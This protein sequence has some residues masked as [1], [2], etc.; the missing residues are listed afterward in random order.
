MSHWRVV[1]VLALIAFPIVFLAGVGGYFMW[2]E[3]IGFYL[4]WPMAASMAAGYL[5]G[6][7]WQRKRQLLPPID[8]TPSMHWT[9]RDR[10]AWQLVEARAKAAER[11]EPARLVEFDFYVKTAEEMAL[12][13]ARFYH[14]RAAD[15]FG[16]RTIPEI[17]AV[18]ELAAHDLA[19]MVDRYLPGGHLLTVDQWRKA[20]QAAEWYQS[21]SNAYWLV[22]ALFSPLNTGLRYAAS[23]VGL[24]KPWQMLQQNLL[25][26]FYTGFVHRTGTYL[27][28]LNSGRLRVGVQRY[29]QLV[30][31]QLPTDQRE[32]E[33]GLPEK[34][35]AD[36]VRRVVITLMGQVK[37][38]KSSLINALLGEQRAQTDVL[39]ATSEVQRYELQ[40]KG[41]PTRLVLL[42]T[43]GYGHEGPRA[44]Q[45]KATEDAAQQSDLLLLVLHARNP[46]RQA[47]LEM[48]RRLRAWFASRPDLRMPPVVAVLTHIDLL[49]PAME[50]APPYNWQ[51]PGRPKE[52]QIEQAV[53]AVREQLGEY[54]AGVVPV[55]T[56][57]GKV[58]GINEWLLP[59]V[60]ALLDEVHAVALLRCLRAEI[61]A[62]KVRKVFHQLLAAGRELVR[63]VWQNLPSQADLLREQRRG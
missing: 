33:A 18:I 35:A 9:D 27:I 20:R 38:G 32:A 40:P 41:I 21:A 12:E 50:W 23:R 53:E 26:W 43:V 24:A 14:P 4:W 31:Q 57:E 48:L 3:D 36:E 51:H 55:C 2:K 42:D 63:I 6:W 37:V 19:E 30:R 49:S 8:F 60:A 11:I 39:P 7:Y 29:R 10:Q 13:L 16:S 1:V 45:L 28:E 46:A 54:L 52:K 22:S 25:L 15:P 17:L 56:A 34:D 59:A 58:Y 62:G 44:D 47:D 5:L 61:D